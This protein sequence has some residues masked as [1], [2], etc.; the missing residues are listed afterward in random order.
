MTASTESKNGATAHPAEAHDA[1]TILRGTAP[2][3]DALDVARIWEPR[4]ALFTELAKDRMSSD[5][6]VTSVRCEA[7]GSPG[8]LHLSLE[9]RVDS[10]ESI[11]RVTTKIESVIVPELEEQLGTAFDR[12]HVSVRASE[13]AARRETAA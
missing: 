10:P 2:I 7:T 6:E 12:K 11:A 9:C 3:T 4:L 13:P 5:P 1:A 8:R